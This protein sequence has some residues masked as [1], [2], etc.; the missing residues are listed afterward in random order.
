MAAGEVRGRRAA[1]PGRPGDAPAA[2]PQAG[3]PPCLAHSLNNLARRAPGSG[4]SY[5][6]FAETLYRRGPEQCTAW[7][8]A[9]RT[10]RCRSER[11]G[12][13]PVGHPDRAPATGSCPIA[14]TMQARPGGGVRGGVGHQGGPRPRLR[15]AGAWPPAPPPPTPRPPPCSTALTDRRRR[16]AELLLAPGPGR[17]RRP[18]QQ[19]DADL[20]AVRPASRG[21]RPRLRPLLPAVDRADKLAKATPADLQKA[22]PA[23]A[24]VV[25]FLRCTLFEQDPKKPGR[26]GE[27]R[28]PRYLAFV[29]TRDKVAGSTSTR[30]SRSRTPSTAWRKAI[31]GGKERPADLPAKVRELVWDKVRKE[32]P[33]GIKT[34]YLS[35]DLALCRRARWRPC[36][37]TSPA[38][39]CW[40]TSPSP[41]SRTLPFLLDKLW[42]QDPSKRPA[43]RRPGRRRRQVRRRPRAR[44]PAARPPR[45]PAAQA[46]PEARLGRSCPAPPPRPRA[47]PPPPRQKLDCASARRRQ[48]DH[49]RRPGRAAEGQV[50]PP[51]HPRLLRRPVVPLRLPARPRLFEMSL[52]GERIGAGPEQPAG[53]DRPGLRRRPTTRRRR[54]AASLTGEALIDLDLSG[55]ELA[56]LSACETG[57]GDVAGGEGTFG[58]QRAFHLAGTRDVVASLWKV[59]DRPPRR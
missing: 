47:S 30:P 33:A 38:P 22:L 42:P 56:V 39:S 53:D 45:R 4:A 32:L 21:P 11:R 49:R 41:S 13:H 17:P 59:P 12:A 24:A 5:D 34:V 55:L 29:V 27:K 58:L 18:A 44:R 54:A 1:L 36:P 8:G 51:R 52:R 6:G 37:A 23:D 57:L 16:R 20:A 40:R 50:R 46:G 35:P 31:T 3:P 15:A 28:T 14:R 25:D 2:V 9:R 43:R 19:R 26:E 48:G 10:P 7:L